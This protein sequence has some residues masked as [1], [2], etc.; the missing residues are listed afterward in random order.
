MK[1]KTFLAISILAAFT[2]SCKK[3]SNNNTPSTN[4]I[5]FVGSDDDYVYA[6]DAVTG[7][8]KWKFKTGEDV[9]SSPAYANGKIF[10]GSND[11]NVYAINAQ[12]GDTAWM[13]NTGADVWYACPLVINDVVYVG[14]IS[15]TIYA[16]KTT[17]TK[18]NKQAEVLWKFK[19]GGNI[20]NSV[21][22]ANNTIYIGCEDGKL[23]ALDAGTGTQK[24]EFNTGSQIFTNPAVVENI[25]YIGTR[26][27]KLYAIE[28]KG[29]IA[30]KKWEFDTGIGNEVDGSPTVVDGTLYITSYS[31]SLYALKTDVT[32]LTR[33]QRLKWKR[34][35]GGGSYSS[36]FVENGIVYVNGGDG[37]LYA[38]KTTDGTDAWPPFTTN[39]FGATSPVVVNGV[40]YVSSGNESVY[41]LNARTGQQVWSQPFVTNDAI[42]SSPCVLTS[43]GKVIYSSISGARQ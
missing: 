3:T 8:Q 39:D 23:Y 31:D 36:P 11:N 42:E 34:Y 26:G 19:A 16:F 29:S 22:Y 14:S 18:P 35:I 33:D 4:A 25:I 13:Y 5:V 27:G 6:I 2:I 12:N 43:D 40:L 38:C 1:L 30:E 9:V 21:T 32:N 37:K 20:S 7:T 41:A 10:V 17:S 24:W 28:D 15:D